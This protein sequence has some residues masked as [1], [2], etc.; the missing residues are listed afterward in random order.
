MTATTPRLTSRKYGTGHVYHLDNER[1]MG[2]TTI[3]SALPGP[4]PSWGAEEAAKFAVNGWEELSE[5][6]LTDRLALIKAAPDRARD[7]AAGRGTELHAYA[8]Q[9]HAGTP[10]EVP[11]EYKV[12]VEAVARW[13]DAWDITAVATETPLAH[14]V[15][16]FGGTADLWARIGRRGDARALI[17]LKTGRTVPGKTVLQLAGYRFADLWQP[18]GPASESTKPD[19][20]LVY[21]AHVGGDDVRMLPVDCR[22]EQLRQLLYVREVANWLK[23]HDWFQR[24]P[25][26][27]PLIGEAERP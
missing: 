26:E 13:L 20:D 23:R 4:P 22:P 12:V 24:K 10:V 7:T 19:V 27:E 15:H 8:E 21:V 6:S 25:G 3:L 11:E 17:D 16:K 14:T 9:L 5:R 18:D 2:V 1:I